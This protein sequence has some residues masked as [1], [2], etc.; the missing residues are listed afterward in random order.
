MIERGSLPRRQ[1]RKR[2]MGAPMLFF[3]S[4]PN[5][6]LRKL[7]AFAIPTEGEFTAA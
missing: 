5:R 3:G 7:L 6:Q 4:L 2:E 1:L